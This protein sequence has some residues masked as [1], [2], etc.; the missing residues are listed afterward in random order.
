MVYDKKEYVIHMSPLDQALKYRL[1][2]DKVHPAVEFDESTWLASYIDFSPQ[3]RTRAKNN[4]EKYIFKL[5]NNSVFGKTMENIR[6]HRDIKLVMNE[7]AYLKKICS[8]TSN[9][10]SLSVRT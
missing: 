1:G 9:Q 4:F 5:M 7:K 6:K 3:L 8:Q 2:L 10:K